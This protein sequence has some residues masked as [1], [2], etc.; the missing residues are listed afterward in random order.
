MGG[1]LTAILKQ[2]VAA[3]G[4]YLDLISIHISTLNS[5]TNRLESQAIYGE[6]DE[7]TI[8]E[9]RL[10]FEFPLIAG[11]HFVGMITL[12]GDQ[13]LSKQARQGLQS[14]ATAIATGIDRVRAREDLHHR[15]EGLLFRLANQIRESLD[16]DTILTTAVNE[17]Q[18]L[19]QVDQCHFLWYVQTADGQPLFMVAH[20]ARSLAL[21]TYLQTYPPD[22]IGEFAAQIHHQE[23]VQIDN[24]E[25]A[26]ELDPNTRDLLRN[27]G[28]CATLILPM[29]TR[30]GQQG[31]II[32]H[33]Y[34]QGQSWGTSE[35]ELLRGVIDQVRSP[36]T[37]PSSTLKP[38]RRP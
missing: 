23:P 17:I 22:Q 14:I 8:S 33:R 38:E 2:C 5:Q 6:E 3:I 7:T 36:L 1:N 21:S 25:T 32:C 26:G 24:I 19:L 34:S 35:V 29:K 27:V 10:K 11:E 37:R 28:I 13:P 4:A 20:E 12:Y 31:A 15:R 18:S 9:T 30:S 16:I